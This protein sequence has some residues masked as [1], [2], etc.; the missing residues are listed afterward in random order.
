LFWTYLIA[1]LKTAAPGVGAGALSLLRSSPH[2]EAVVGALLYDLTPISN[3]VVLV[4]D[5]YHLI[6]ARE[7]G[8][9]FLLEHL[10]RQIHLVIACR[11]DP[12]LPLAR[13]RGG[14][15]LVEIAQ[16]TALHA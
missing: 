16:L 5:H 9:A 13:L 10:P 15:E 6:D 1:A 3:D 12:P 8:A 7:G 11:A 4:L 14:G 2:F